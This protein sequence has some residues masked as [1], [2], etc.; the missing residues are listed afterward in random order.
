MKTI[1]TAS[2]KST[3]SLFDKRFGRAPWF[4]LFNEVTGDIEFIENKNASLKKGAGTS[5]VNKLKSL[6]IQKIISGDFGEKTKNALESNNIQ[7]VIMTEN[8]T[9]QQIIDLFK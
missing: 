2:G 6:D 7:M 3:S 9:I 8:K 5:A 4:C 1:I